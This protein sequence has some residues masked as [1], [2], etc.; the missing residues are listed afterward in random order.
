M[1]VDDDEVDD[2]VPQVDVINFAMQAN[3]AL[4]TMSGEKH[5][6]YNH[7]SDE[8]A[9]SKVSLVFFFFLSLFCCLLLLITIYCC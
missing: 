3:A 4:A 2:V 7:F 1:D 5:N 9:V 6:A 8:G